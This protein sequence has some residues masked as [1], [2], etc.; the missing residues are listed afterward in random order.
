VGNTWPPAHLRAVNAF[1]L[2]LLN[3][4]VLL[5]RG[6]TV[7]V[8]HHRLVGGRSAERWVLWTVLLGLYFT[9]LQATEYAHTRFSI[10]DSCFGAIFFV[11]TGFHGT[12]V[13]VGA[14]TL[15]VTLGRLITGSLGP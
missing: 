12:H 13:L 14:T 9:A 5:S 15:A 6:A 10:R 7:T 2:P 8:A 1:H 4:A 11:A 3:T